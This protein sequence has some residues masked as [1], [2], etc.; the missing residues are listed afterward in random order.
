MRFPGFYG[1]DGLKLRLSAAGR[2]LSHCYILEG[3]PGSGKKTLATI[4]A[5]AMECEAGGEFPCGTCPACRKILKLEHPDVI[6]VDSDTA[7]VPI[8]LIRDMQADAYVKPNEGRKKVYLLPR[9][10]DMQAP[11]Q[12]ALLK[13]LEEPPE[14]CAFLLMTDS[15]EKLL[16]TVR[17]RAVTLT[18]SPLSRQQLMTALKER[19]PDAVQEDL[20]RAMDKSEGYL[21]AALKLLHTPETT[22]DRL[23]AE[24]TAAFASG[25]EL[26]L[27]T[28]LLPLEKLKRQELLSLL[29]GLNRTFAQ[30]MD[31]GAIHTE[32]TRIL[33]ASCSG[34]QLFDAARAISYAITLLQANGSA[35]H[36]VGSLMAQLRPFS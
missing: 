2:K 36:A 30:A 10:Q 24:V 1:N 13:L 25:D 7:T 26:K 16:E 23:A 19:E 17:S 12:N 9:A 4:L 33:A 35:G 31:P 20:V 27:L 21:G 28:A 14:Y 3:P 18:L 8:R 5:A 15:I 34:Q 29:T 32:D 22:L 11:A 6:T